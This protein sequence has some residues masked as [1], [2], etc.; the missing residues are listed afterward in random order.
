MALEGNISDFSIP[1]ILQLISSQR[2]NGVLT[3]TQGGDEAA[4]DLDEGYITGGYYK[5][6]GRQEHISEYLFK[7]GLVS[8]PRFTE[9]EE[10]Q[11]KLG[12]PLEE[13][14]IEQGFLSQD[15]FEEVIRFKI[16]EIMDEIFTWMDGHYVFDVKVRLYTKTKY[17]IR[18]AVDSFLLE[19]MRRLDEWMRIKKVLPDLNVIVRPAPIM[20]QTLLDLTAEQEKLMEFLSNRHLPVSGLVSMSGLGKYVTCQTV[21]ELLEQRVLETVDRPA[22]APAPAPGTAFSAAAHVKTVA[23]LAKQLGLLIKNLSRYPFNHPQIISNLDGFSHLL[24]NLPLNGQGLTLSGGIGPTLING[25]EVEDDS[26]ILAQFAIYLHQRQL[27]N[28]TF[29]PQVRDDELRSLA[30]LLSMPLDL[31]NLLGGCE[32]ISKV[33]RWRHIKP[34]CPAQQ[35]ERLLSGEKV[36]FLPSSFLQM[37]DGGLTSRPTLPP[38]ILQSL[39]TV[40]GFKEPVLQPGEALAIE[41]ADQA[42]EKVFS[43]Y[44]RGGRE[45][46]IEK[47]VTGA[48][49]LQPAPRLALLKRKLLDIRWLFPVDNILALSHSEFERL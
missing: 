26:G 5:K 24:S 31:I 41:E 27:E 18:L 4:F 22:P 19:G 38:Q 8:E 12:V 10:Q 46:Y 49:K 40:A 29:L 9:A 36:F 44:S 13:I 37:A 16:Q 14:L 25:Q 47:V 39:K 28:L 11:K 6:V 30:Y 48:M 32:Q 17:P 35:P 23:L 43:V 3:L 1:E 45:K 7:T 21:A 34:E 15:D 33:M 20:P 2:K 42:T